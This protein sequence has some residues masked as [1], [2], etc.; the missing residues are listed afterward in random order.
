MNFTNHDQC[1]FPFTRSFCCLGAYDHH[2][3]QTYIF[4]ESPFLDFC[5]IFPFTAQRLFSDPFLSKYI[6]PCLEVVCI[7]HNRHHLFQ[8]VI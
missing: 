1:I 4:L 2:I 6:L 8:W 7:P 3:G 5:L